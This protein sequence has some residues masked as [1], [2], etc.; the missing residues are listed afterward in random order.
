[1]PK[2]WPSVGSA[3]PDRR[4]NFLEVTA[5]PERDEAESASFAA[6]GLGTVYEEVAM[7]VA[8]IPSEEQSENEWN[9]PRS[10][11]ALLKGAAIAAGAAGAVALTPGEAGAASQPFFFNIRDYGAVGDGVT[12]DSSSIQAAINAASAV[13][14][15]VVQFPAGHYLLTA[16]L[17]VPNGVSLEGVGWHSPASYSNSFEGSWIYIRASQNGHNFSPITVNGRGSAIRKL[18][19]YLPEM[20]APPTNPDT[21][22]PYTIVVNG[23]DVLIEDIHLYNVAYGI[24][25]GGVGRTKM[26]RITGQPLATGIFMNQNH[27]TMSID[28]VHFWP[29]WNASAWTFQNGIGIDSYANDNPLMSNIFCAGYKYGIHFGMD[30]NSGSTVKWHLNNIDLDN[31]YWEF[32]LTEST[33]ISPSPLVR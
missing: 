27:D 6:W 15:G 12:S 28:N 3:L 25:V 33:S 2:D 32:I 8:K 20:P 18:A 24:H 29:F 11:R 17:T 13:A 26:V 23:D 4:S 19:F 7:H 14:G 5:S 1:M 16:S 21:S 22:Y 30:A 9:P 10:R 31:C